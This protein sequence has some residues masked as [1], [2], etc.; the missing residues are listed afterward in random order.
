MQE[1]KHA[2]EIRERLLGFDED[3]NERLNYAQKFNMLRRKIANDTGQ[4][5]LDTEI[6]SRWLSDEKL[7]ASDPSLWLH[8]AG[9]SRAETT[10]KQGGADG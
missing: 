3:S 10:F 9:T 4:W 6:V 1:S 7:I 5:L 8:G 2:K